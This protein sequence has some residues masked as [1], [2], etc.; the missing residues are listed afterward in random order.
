MIPSSEKSNLHCHDD[1]PR[2]LAHAKRLYSV[3]SAVS[4]AVSRKPAQGEL[5]QDICRILVETGGLR[6][7]W[8]G[9]PD[10]AGWLVPAW[11]FGEA[12]DYLEGIRISVHDIPEGRGTTG[13]AIRERRPVVC[14][15]IG[16]YDGMRPW[17]DAALARGIRACASFPVTL[18]KEDLGVLTVYAD[19]VDFFSVAEVALFEEICQELSFAL[20]FSATE[21]D[22]ERERNLLKALV[23]AIP[24]M[25]WLKDPQ[26][27]YL[28]CNRAMA[29]FCGFSVGEIVGSTDYDLFSR[30][31]AEAYRAKDHQ[32]L[33]T[34]MAL[35]YDNLIISQQ[36]LLETI[37]TPVAGGVGELIGVLGIAHDVTEERRAAELL[38]ASEAKHT[39]I[40]KT[41]MDGFLL[42]DAEGRIRE[43]NA[44]YCRMS[45]YREQELLTMNVQD[46]EAAETAE[47]TAT[48]IHHIIAH[49]EDHFESRHRRKDGSVFDI[50]V[51]VQ[52]QADDGGR[53]VSFVRDITERKKAEA[54]LHASESRFRLLFEQHND[55]MLLIEPASGR[56][57][58][59][60]NAAATFYGYARDTLQTMNVEQINCLPPAS[61]ITE[62]NLAKDKTKTCFVFPHR[63]AD[64]TER[65]VEVHSTAITLTDRPLLF[66]IIHD[67]TRQQREEHLLKSRL[68]LM[69]YGLSHT[70]GELLTETLNEIEELTGSRIGFFH[71]VNET[72]GTLELQAW[73]TRTSRDFC[74]AGGG[75]SHYGID[76]AGVWADCVRQRQSVVHNDYESL[77]NRHGLPEW[78]AR[79]IRELTVPIMRGNQVVAVLGIGNKESIY[80]EEDV[81]LVAHFAD[82]TW[83]ITLR[84]LAEDELAAHRHHLEE[85]V[86]ARTAELA[87]AVAQ[88]AASEERYEYALA[89]ANDG[90][91]DWNIIT[92][93][94][95]YNPLYFQMLGYEPGELGLR[96]ES[97]WIERLHPEEREYV[98]ATA[99]QRLADDGAYE[100]E[101]RMRTKDGGYKWI[102]SRGKV[103]ARDA[104]GRPV[105]A[106]GTHTD[107]T[108]R[109][110][111]EL[112]LRTAK[113]RSEAATRAKSDFLANMSHELRTPLGA[114]LGYT[115]IFQ[116]GLLGPVTEEQ[117]RGIA[118]IE[119][120]GRHLLAL[121]TDILDLAKIEA[122]MM[123]AVLEPVMV[124][125][126]CQASLLF[127][128]EMASKKQIGV[129]FTTRNQPLFF[130]TDQRRLK[131]IL[132]NLLSNA[133][134]FTP[135]GGEVG[136]EA[137][138]CPV[139][140]QASFTV[141]DTGIGITAEDQARLFKPFT[142][143]DS[144]L[145]RQHE[146]TGLGLALVA[147]LVNLLKG[148]VS[149]TS[150]PGQ[151]SRFT[152]TLPWEECPIAAPPQALDV[153]E[154]VAL[155]FSGGFPL[156]LVVEDN[157]SNGELLTI[158]LSKKGFKTILATSGEEAVAVARDNGP[159]VIFMDIQMPG[160]SGLEAIRQIRM[161][162]PPVNGVPIIACTALAMPGDRERCLEAGADRYLT[163]PVDLRELVLQ[164]RTLLPA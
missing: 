11:S 20:A 85:L 107:Q 161:L 40:L 78:H 134:K 124:E 162:A 35:R 15:E 52:Y 103:V 4:R 36:R 152:I 18:P 151:G 50:D 136:L 153:V 9:I 135:V 26:G 108:Q 37:K 25:V 64:G 28:F 38:Q 141:W 76:Q 115:E 79:V 82:L 21:A 147:S 112:E 105:R 83:D 138:W 114:I 51:N 144:T 80:T 47:S 155:T 10:A 97:Y 133:V 3:L 102:L 121:I 140:L 123:E 90:L 94:V 163:K 45:G 53:F 128:K 44:A 120:S 132:V 91:W 54:A 46:V 68:R 164:L 98:L 116:N 31:A 65:T 131:Q 27:V 106:V 13:T 92:G 84:K 118:T 87:S 159:A 1:Q 86:A 158:Y 2:R 122:D 12:R 61:V 6:L 77:P 93:A 117:Q 74:S 60:N 139:R 99:R 7:S 59:A 41:A 22:L 63:L 127:V 160:M 156:V 30:D 119:K 32:I 75:G 8:F 143:V 130:R 101:F 157:A 104:A 73:S 39:T 49:G 23:G 89:A 34:G 69:E 150:T 57:V 72:A 149:L 145:S 5:L 110:Q 48:H 88:I 146:G 24:D 95:Y 55:V 67:I 142:Q 33:S 81:A 56:I 109:K 148:E 29:N 126:L 58:D 137:N 17:Q 42:V 113:E 154:E 66:S 125:D 70:I 19:E 43:V 62:R 96:T 71:F 111:M 16:A 100:L 14:N 129:T